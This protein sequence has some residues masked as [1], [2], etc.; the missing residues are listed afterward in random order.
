MNRVNPK[1]RDFSRRLI[2]YEAKESK[3]AGTN[4]PAVFPVPEKLRPHLATLMGTFG[5]RSLLSRA[6]ALAGAEVSWL[7]AVQVNADGSLPG[8]DKLAA[9][10]APPDLFEGQVVLLAQLLGL[11]VAF[12]GENLTLRLLHEAWPNLPR[13]KNDLNFN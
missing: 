8:L 11:L 7:R 12:I 1:L 10:V 13:G 4:P 3:S 9:P 6:L 5:F 2:A